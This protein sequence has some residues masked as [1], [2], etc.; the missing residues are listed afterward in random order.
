[1][2]GSGSPLKRGKRLGADSIIGGG[3]V[4]TGV[5]GTGMSASS[6][7]TDP[8]DVPGAAWASYSAEHDVNIV[9][10]PVDEGETFPIETAVGD[11]HCDFWD[12]VRDQ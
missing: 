8:R 6:A 3:D 1:M 11:R 12:S 5:K 10:Q 2:A 4:S 9:L 7:W